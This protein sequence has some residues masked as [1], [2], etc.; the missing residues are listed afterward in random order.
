V[1]RK[2]LTQALTRL[3]VKLLSE[4]NLTDLGHVREV[5]QL[6]EGGP[7]AGGDELSKADQEVLATAVEAQLP[8]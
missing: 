5:R 7:G 2:E 3:E 6:L 1:T 8:R 4:R